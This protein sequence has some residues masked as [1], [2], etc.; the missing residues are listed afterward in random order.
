M[1][2]TATKTSL[3]LFIF[4]ITALWTVGSVMAYQGG[5][6]I[7]SCHDDIAARRDKP[8]TSPD[9]APPILTEEAAM[10]VL[11]NFT[12]KKINKNWYLFLSHKEFEGGLDSPTRWKTISLLSTLR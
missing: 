8:G 12:V 4:I 9:C 2:N 1:K 5:S 3:F 10:K 7:P 6:G 11:N